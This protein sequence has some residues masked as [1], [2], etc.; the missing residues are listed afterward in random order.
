MSQRARGGV[1]R[2]GPKGK[3]RSHG[4]WPHNKVVKWLQGQSGT[5]VWSASQ[6][7]RVRNAALQLH[8]V[9]D[10]VL[11]Q[12]EEAW[13]ESSKASFRPSSSDWLVWSIS[14]TPSGGWT[15]EVLTLDGPRKRT[16]VLDP[17]GP[18]QTGSMRGWPLYSSSDCKTQSGV[19][20]APQAQ[21]PA[22]H[23]SRHLPQRRREEGGTGRPG[24]S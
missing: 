12:V 8:R 17:A 10:Q 20:G 23:R 24:R 2:L 18:Q 13:R 19:S 14:N 16:T 21:T 6:N 11:D 5:P 15:D 7:S 4:A 22:P 3:G 1:T 9:L